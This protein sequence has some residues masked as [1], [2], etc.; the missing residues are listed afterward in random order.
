[1]RLW[2]T[3]PV[4]GVTLVRGEG[5]RVWDDRGR[6]YVDLLSGTWCNV[7]GYGC[8]ELVEA[9]RDQAGKLV[10]SGTPFGTREV[11]DALDALREIVPPKLDRVVLTN[12]GSESVELALKIACA[13]SGG[14]PSAVV[15]GGYYG[16][17]S[18]A[19]SLSEAGRNATWLPGSE[20]TL[21]LPTPHCARCPKRE[22]CRGTCP[23]LD[24]FSD[25]LEAAGGRISAVLYEPVIGGGILVPP[26]GYGKRLRKFAD[27]CGALLIAEE[28]TTGMGR[29][30]KWF[31][32]E[33]DDITPDILV[34]GKILGGGLPVAAVVTTE[35]VERRSADVLGRHVQSH[36]NDPFSG[37]IASTVIGILS[38]GGFVERARVVGERLLGGLRKLA[39][40]IPAIRDVR[41]RGA[42][43]G[44]EL[45]PQYADRGP[46]LSRALLDAGFIQDFHVPTST[47]RL[48]PPFVTETDDLD[49]F[50]GAFG[51]SA[52]ALLR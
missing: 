45:A 49:A 28:V 4:S 17:T 15:G 2:R 44:A 23:C 26:V 22:T 25:Q 33:H 37:R 18:Y 30:G 50:T 14:A 16:A 21:R 20:S 27:S 52:A 41:G 39:R 12:T 35:D 19:Y 11:D 24:P 42:M 34:L 3:S 31:G 32:F 10:H 13:A 47:L 38:R 36:Q 40:E 43:V 9:I 46:E 7:L 5:T 29:T 51:R 1:M 8:P 6:S 48:F